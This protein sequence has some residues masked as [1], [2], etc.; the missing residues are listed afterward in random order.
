MRSLFRA[1]GSRGRDIVKASSVKRFVVAG[2][3]VRLSAALAALAFVLAG[4]GAGPAP[5]ATCQG[6]TGGQAPQAATTFFSGV[7]VFSACD[8]WAVG[9]SIV[10]GRNTS[11][12]EHWTGGSSWTAVPSPSPSPGR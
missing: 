12:I 4:F 10:S 8:V 9:R 5:A 2:V 1:A 6:F 7:A 11:L 3:G